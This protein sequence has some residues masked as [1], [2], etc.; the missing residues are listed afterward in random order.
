MLEERQGNDILLLDVRQITILA[1]YYILC[2]ATSERQIKAL[3]GDLSRQLKAEAGRPL[4]SEGTPESGWI[5]LDYGGVVVHLF[6]PEI[7]RF[8]ALEDL[9]EKAQTVVHIQ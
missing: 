7:R 1:D 5:L 4:S 9:W 8:Y 6:L 3:A 2:S